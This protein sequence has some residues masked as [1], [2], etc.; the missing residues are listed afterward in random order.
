MLPLKTTAR[1]VHN[2]GKM[3]KNDARIYLLRSS[4][5]SARFFSE[6]KY[7]LSAYMRFKMVFKMVCAACSSLVEW[8]SPQSK[9]VVVKKIKLSVHFQESFDT[10]N[11]GFLIEINVVCF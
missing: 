5:R 2:L 6:K 7:F 10:M 1:I 3:T 8:G 11:G 4:A 9:K